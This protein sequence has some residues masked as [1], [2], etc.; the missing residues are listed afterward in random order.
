[1]DVDIQELL[2]PATAPRGA[3]LD[4][5][6]LRRRVRRR[7]RTRAFAAVAAVVLLVP[8]ART[9]LAAP[10]A[11]V[12]FTSPGAGTSD[13]PGGGEDIYSSHR[14]L[15]A[16]GIDFVAAA[17]SGEVVTKKNAVVA[18]RENV[19]HVPKSVTVVAQYGLA[20][21]IDTGRYDQRP[22]WAVRFSDS[23]DP[24]S[25]PDK[26]ASGDPATPV[27][28]TVVLVDAAAGEVLLTVSMSRAGG[29][30]HEAVSEQIIGHGA[31]G[32]RSSAERAH[33]LG[34]A[35][36]PRLAAVRAAKNLGRVDVRVRSV[37]F[38]ADSD[39]RVLIEDSTG[40]WVYAAN[41]LRTRAP[42][43]ASGGDAP[44]DP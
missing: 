5:T 3:P 12:A 19:G 4:V 6:D 28:V 13:A 30:Q 20:T 35:A 44:C 36:T 33:V 40:C 34:R 16:H 18:A 7:R 21:D 43:R 17:P 32:G 9:H 11:N 24:S 1:M 31:S 42:W 14:V 39:T 10:R 15:R 26:R 38:I 27:G 22:A 25:E 2:R 41:R 8:A 37:V 29:M 23:R